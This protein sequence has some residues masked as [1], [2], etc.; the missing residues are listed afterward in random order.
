MGVTFF[1]ENLGKIWGKLEDDPK[2]DELSWEKMGII[3][4]SWE[5][6]QQQ[7]W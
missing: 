6:F 7:K 3:Q 5:N 2:L 1:S 4:E